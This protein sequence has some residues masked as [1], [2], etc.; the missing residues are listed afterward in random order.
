MEIYEKISMGAK[1]IGKFI[2]QQVAAAMAKKTKQYEKK[3][4][5]WRKVGRTEYQESQKKPERGA[6]DAPKRKIKHSQL[7]RLQSQK[8]PNNLRLLGTWPK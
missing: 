5:N 3:I 4:G 7:R 2:T 1:L 8:H 6:V